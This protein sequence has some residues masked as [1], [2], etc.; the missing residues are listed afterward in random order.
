MGD[1]ARDDHGDGTDRRK[2]PQKN[3]KLYGQDK[4]RH[5]EGRRRRAYDTE[6]GVEGSLV[7]RGEVGEAGKE[8]SNVDREDGEHGG[9]NGDTNDT[10][11]LEDGQE[12]PRRVVKREGERRSGLLAVDN[13]NG[14]GED[15]REDRRGQGRRRKLNKIRMKDKPREE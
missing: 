10:E 12:D 15:D 11:A 4:R 6:R 9:H 8:R 7:V 1:D 2:D 5:V 13:D 14:R 3:A